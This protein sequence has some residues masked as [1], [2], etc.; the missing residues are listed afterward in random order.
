MPHPTDP[1]EGDDLDDLPPPQAV[2]YA[3][4]ALLG[5]LLLEPHRLDTIGHLEPHHFGNHAHNALFTAI[6]T[7]SSPD[8]KQ[9]AKDT[10]WLGAVLAKAR[11]E[12]P[13]LTA[14]YLHTLIQSCPRPQHATAYAGMIRADHARRTLREHA[15][16]LCQTATD[17]T[18]PDPAVAVLVQADALGGYL[19][20]LTPQFTPHPGSLPR[21]PAP[22]PPPP[23]A[24]EEA[25]DEERLLLATA[26][27][28]PNEVAIMRWL[29]PDDFTH[30]LHAGLWQCLVALTR[31]DT[32][33]DPVTVLWEA[34]HR[35]LLSTGAEPSELLDLL[36][37]P[38]GS[39]EYWGERILQ[40][41]V[42]QVAHHIGRR[43]EAFTQ[44][45]ATT[46]YQLVVG[47]RRALA[48]L[49]AVRTRWQHAT[50]PAPES[51]P[52]RTRGTAAPRTSPPRTTAPHTPRISR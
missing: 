5:A 51:K 23:E 49:T 38:V 17:T 8:P 7:V 15:D 6:R 36:A 11:H 14:S 50:S 30:P 40:R 10:A 39:P 12:A 44:D 33:V 22:P 4:Q 48:D 35:G 42:L 20:E 25:L 27:A 41:S 31:R 18:L 9:H 45:P 24:G 21:T 37:G 52:A 2:H 34:Q 16:R 47:S 13:G 19:D 29:Q 28:H 3:E 43:I 46:P 32:P 26:T 1:Y